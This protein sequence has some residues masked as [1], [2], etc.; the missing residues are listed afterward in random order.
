MYLPK[1]SETEQM[2]D[3]APSIY[4]IDLEAVAHALD[5][6]AEENCK[7]PVGFWLLI[8]SGLGL[9]LLLVLFALAF[10]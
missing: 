9:L 10:F 2:P 1:P 8:F 7:V 6:Q 4:G 3:Q 5:Q